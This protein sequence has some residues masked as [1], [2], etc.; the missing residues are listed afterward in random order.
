MKKL[1][2]ILIIIF[3]GY[4]LIAQNDSIQNTSTD[5]QIIGEQVTSHIVDGVKIIEKIITVVH[6]D[7]YIDGVSNTSLFSLI[8]FL[9]TT[10][11][12]LL[13]RRKE[14]KHLKKTGKLNE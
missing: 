13:A 8:T 5:N 2:F 10:I 12:A 6:P 4:A 11:G 7:S 9:A 1:F 3:T 14:K